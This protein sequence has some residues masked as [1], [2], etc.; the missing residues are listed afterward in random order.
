[1]QSAKVVL[2][3][4]S[5]FFAYGVSAVLEIRDAFTNMYLVDLLV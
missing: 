2:I 4:C 3:L 1:M 5:C